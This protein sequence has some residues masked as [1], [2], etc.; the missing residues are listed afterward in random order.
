GHFAVRLLGP[1][2]GILLSGVFGGLASATALTVSFARLARRR[3][4]LSNLLAT[5]TILAQAVTLPRMLAVTWFVSQSLAAHALA[6][7]AAMTVA[8]LVYGFVLHGRTT[9]ETR[10]AP[11]N[12]GPPFRMRET[13]RFGALLVAITLISAAMN[14]HFGA[15]GVYLVAALGALTNLTA[16]TLSIAEL[17]RHGLDNITATMALVMSAISSGLFKALLGGWLGSRQL[18]IR[19]GIAALLAS[20][21]GFI[22]LLWIGA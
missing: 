6:P 2:R 16:V 1:T 21:A 12:L 17:A 13:L 9:I 4:R 20:V 5:G 14:H 19:A 7:L 15:A 3:P 18:G 11:R 8:T 10:K 22:A